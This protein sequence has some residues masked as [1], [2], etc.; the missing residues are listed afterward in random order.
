MGRAEQDLDLL[1]DAE[2][3][4][5]QQVADTTD[6]EYGNTDHGRL[7]ALRHR[8]EPAG[9]VGHLVA[10]DPKDDDRAGHPPGIDQPVRRCVERVEAVGHAMAP[11]VDG[12][13]G[14]DDQRCGAEPGLILPGDETALG[15]DVGAAHRASLSPL[16]SYPGRGANGQILLRHARSNGSRHACGAIN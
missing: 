12:Q 13:A 11:G 1:L 3:R 8:V 16:M 5:P 14:H 7:E 6:A 4:V 10:Y 9:A 15:R 2:H